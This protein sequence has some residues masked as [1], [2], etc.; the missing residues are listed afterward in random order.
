M[1]NK[2]VTDMQKSLDALDKARRSLEQAT[3]GPR[4]SFLPDANEGDLFVAYSHAVSKAVTHW[5]SEASWTVDADTWTFNP[6]TKRFQFYYVGRVELAR[7]GPPLQ[8]AVRLH[9]DPKQPVTG[10][11]ER[12]GREAKFY[13]DAASLMN[14]RAANGVAL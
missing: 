2:A 13:R 3:L 9:L 14:V 1:K 7:P 6:Y 4:A 12:L 11:L 8:L 5:L 10:E